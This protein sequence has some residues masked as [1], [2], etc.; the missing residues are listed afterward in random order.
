MAGPLFD[1]HFHVFDHPMPG[2]RGFVPEPFRVADYR[3]RTAT[4]GVVG[5]AV[6]AGSMEGTDPARL[7]CVDRRC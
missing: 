3:A 1:A 5:G 2:H 7:C 4:L 6:V